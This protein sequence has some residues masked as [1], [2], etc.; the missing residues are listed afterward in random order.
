MINIF[1]T[2]YWIIERVPQCISKVTAEKA[3]L[4]RMRWFLKKPGP[5]PLLVTHV[6][7]YAK[8][9]KK[10]I[11]WVHKWNNDFPFNFKN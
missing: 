11:T 8:Q 6:H 4:I 3:S 5:M 7:F 9:E 1:S 2:L 10:E